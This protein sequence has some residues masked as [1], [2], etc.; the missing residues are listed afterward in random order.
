MYAEISNC[1]AC[2]SPRLKEV[3]D[4]G[5]SALSGRFPEPGE[6]D[7]P[8]GPVKLMLCEECGLGQLAHEYEQD[9]LYRHNY[10][11]RSGINATMSEHLAKLVKDVLGRRS[12]APGDVVLDIGSNDATLLNCYQNSGIQRIGMDPTIAQYGEYYSDDILAVADYFSADNFAAI[13][14][15]KAKIITSIA[16]FY[17]LA[18]PNKFVSDIAASL[19]EDGLWVLELCYAK[20]MIEM[21]AFDTVCHEHATYYGLEQISKMVV[22]HGLRVCDVSFSDV[23][24]GS[25]RI[26]VCH[27]GADFP[28][29]EN[30]ENALIEESEFGLGSAAKYIEFRE[31]V[32]A[33]MESL[34]KLVNSLKDEGKT[35]CAY[36]AS[37]KGNILLQYCGF[38]SGEI[39]A[40]A[41]RNPVKW[42][43]RTPGTNI[44][45]ISEEDARAQH[46][47]YFLVLPWHFRDEFIEREADYL[48]GGGRMIFPL[49]ILEVI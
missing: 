35:I 6:A 34:R 9:E 3:F 11:Y 43:R 37:T 38:T 21:N 40:V 31:H 28:V 46:P 26:F 12:L 15:G 23:N 4:L 1:R 16:M 7:A 5:E 2:K 29:S 48:S 20:R 47:D 33:Q 49:P 10:G 41:D 42:G 22:P 39:E 13:S 14:S 30:V 25:F 44:P 17:D 18:D 24:G 32:D 45:I 8:V 36:G 27:Q 19:A